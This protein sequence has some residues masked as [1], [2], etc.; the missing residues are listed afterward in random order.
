VRGNFA[1]A[2]NFAMLPA[3]YVPPTQDSMRECDIGQVDVA[4][5]E[6]F[7]L[8]SGIRKCTRKP[9]TQFANH[10]DC[11][12]VSRQVVR[13]PRFIKHF[14]R[15]TKDVLRDMSRIAK[16]TIA[17]RRTKGVQYHHCMGRKISGNR[18]EPEQFKHSMDGSTRRVWG[19]LNAGASDRIKTLQ[20]RRPTI[21][22]GRCRVY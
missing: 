14:S 22:R 20:G 21:H 12:R 17:T 13:A 18:L 10:L 16:G 6:C 9:W 19:G 3:G 7:T 4:C 15:G 2:E 8:V 5:V 1:E 11:Q